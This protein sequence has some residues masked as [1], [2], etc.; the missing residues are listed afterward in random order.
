M[1]L[2]L[3]QD[4]FSLQE[5]QMP[6]GPGSGRAV[7]QA[8]L[9][10]SSIV[11]ILAVSNV[12]SYCTNFW[13][14]LLGDQR[15]CVNEHPRFWENPNLQRWQVEDYQ[16]WE[17]QKMLKVSV[18]GIFPL[19][20]LLLII[21]L[22]EHDVVRPVRASLADGRKGESEDRS[23]ATAGSLKKVTR[24]R[25]ANWK[26]GCWAAIYWSLNS[27]PP[28]TQ[29][30]TFGKKPLSMVLRLQ[31]CPMPAPWSPPRWQ[32]LFTFL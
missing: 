32:Q 23:K 14:L 13:R 8:G 9:S 16:F 19:F 6:R 11:T 18:C 31:R 25:T 2:D 5:V 27:N 10:G 20:W 30:L 15:V 28:A 26:G 24:G 17:W 22:L 29:V 3:A 21:T 4:P 7:P 1:A 12:V